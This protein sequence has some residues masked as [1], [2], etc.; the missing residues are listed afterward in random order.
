V[1]SLSILVAPLDISRENQDNIGR[2]ITNHSG[3]LSQLIVS[4]PPYI[5]NI[6]ILEET[7]NCITV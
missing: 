4:W 3:F 7:K 2:D 6:S 5:D 1:L